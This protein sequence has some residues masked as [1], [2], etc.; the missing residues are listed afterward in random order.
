M[1]AGWEDNSKICVDSLYSAKKLRELSRANALDGR[2]MNVGHQC[3]HATRASL[4]LCAGVGQISSGT[5]RRYGRGACVLSPTAAAA[6]ASSLPLCAGRVGALTRASDVE[7]FSTRGGADGHL[8]RRGEAFS[9]LRACHSGPLLRSSISSR[10]RELLARVNVL[11]LNR[12][13]VYLRRRFRK[14]S[15][16]RGG[17]PIDPRAHGGV[18]RV[19]PSPRVLVFIFSQSVLAALACAVTFGRD[20]YFSMSVPSHWTQP[21]GLRLQRSALSLRLHLGFGSPALS[22]F[23]HF[24]LRTG[25]LLQSVGL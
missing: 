13:M 8:L 6:A 1:I 25:T 16:I 24:E 12:E 20:A 18:A 7:S 22:S 11:S 10:R 21:A 3:T 5:R 4:T 9:H 2:Q 17:G 23:R 15:L 14:V 19:A